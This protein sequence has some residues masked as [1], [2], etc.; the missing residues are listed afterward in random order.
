MSVTPG[1]L[2]AGQ[3]YKLRG[4]SVWTTWLDLVPKQKNKDKIGVLP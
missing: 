2:E 4:R 1:T 3:K